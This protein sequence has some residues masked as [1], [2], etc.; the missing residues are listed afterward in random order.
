MRR[1]RIDWAPTFGIAIAALTA[2]LTYTS[3]RLDKVIQEQ[4]A[5]KAARTQA[6]EEQNN[7][8]EALANR[9]ASRNRQLTLAVSLLGVVVAAVAIKGVLP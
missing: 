2:Y 9:Q 8:R 7:A 3:L 6:I 1:R 4:N 5:G